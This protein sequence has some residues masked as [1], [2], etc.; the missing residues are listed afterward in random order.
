MFEHL[1]AL[2]V[3]LTVLLLLFTAI[4]V[5]AARGRH[6]IKAPAVEGHPEFERAFRAQMN[7]LEATVM[8]L[9]SLW[10]A[11]EYGGTPWFAGLIGLLWVLARTWYALAYLRNATKRGAP[12][13]LGTLCMAILLGWGLIG[14]LQAMLHA[15]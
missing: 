8:F 7:T 11:S 6:G 14:V 9:P 10:L 4:K 3:A 2:D 13:A 5:G 15:A 1:P 12:F